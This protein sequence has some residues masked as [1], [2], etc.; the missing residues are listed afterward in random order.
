MNTT[1]MNEKKKVQFNTNT[2]PFSF[3]QVL[4]F[5]SLF[6]P[7]CFV[8]LCV[9]IAPQNPNQKNQKNENKNENKNEKNE[10]NNSSSSS[11]CQLNQNVR[12]T[13]HRMR[14]IPSH[15]PFLRRNSQRKKSKRKPEVSAK[16]V[17]YSN[18]ILRVDANR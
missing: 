8:L 18:V 3:L 7:L 9:E 17:K 13:Y 4:L 2:T 5:V 16:C 14:R 11:N 10:E 6:A 12:R 1:T 15:Q